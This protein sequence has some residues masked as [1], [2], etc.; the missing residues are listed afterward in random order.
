MVHKWLKERKPWV[1]LLPHSCEPPLGC[2]L[3]K[4]QR[5]LFSCLR[6]AISSDC[7]RARAMVQGC[8][9]SLPGVLLIV[10]SS[11]RPS[12]MISYWERYTEKDDLKPSS[13]DWSY[14]G[15][16]GLMRRSVRV[17]VKS[18]G[19]GVQAWEWGVQKSTG[20]YTTLWHLPLLR[21]PPRHTGLGDW[22]ARER[23]EDIGEEVAKESATDGVE[24]DFLTSCTVSRSFF[25]Q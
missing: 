21:L 3:K 8:R 6:Q 14:C 19:R 5:K 25:L 7:E 4:W 10:G 17:G 15:G 20:A 16:G 18:R 9:E 2:A 1:C 22:S 13:R 23:Q 12:K 11:S 24:G